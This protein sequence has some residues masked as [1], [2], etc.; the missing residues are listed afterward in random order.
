MLVD[1]EIGKWIVVAIIAMEGKL[2]VNELSVF[3]LAV[4]PEE[5]SGDKD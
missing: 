3:R 1:I 5:F 4:A 2:Q